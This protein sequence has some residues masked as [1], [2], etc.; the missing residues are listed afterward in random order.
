[1]TISAEPV[2]DLI[3]AFRRSQTMFAAV[4]LGA[5]DAMPGTAAEIAAKIGAPT[6]ATERLLD[7]CAAIGLLEK[8]GDSYRNSA[9]TERYICAA[10]PDSLRGYI[11]YS[12]Q[13]L[14]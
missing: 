1:M 12:H 6:D 9:V 5:F 8:S 3:E 7:G 4:S 10:S 13:A 11:M 14:Y 2:I